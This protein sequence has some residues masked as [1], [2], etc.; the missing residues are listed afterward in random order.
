MLAVQTQALQSGIE[1]LN[2]DTLAELLQQP[3]HVSASIAKQ[4]TLTGAT[5]FEYAK[6]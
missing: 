4:F 3:S 2:P 1:H 6:Q 5:V